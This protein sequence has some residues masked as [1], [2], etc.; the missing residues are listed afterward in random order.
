MN[1]RAAQLNLTRTHYA[2]PHGL[3]NYKNVSSAKDVATLS[4]IAM[5]D[6]TFRRIVNKKTY[7]CEIR[8]V[9]DECRTIVWK[10]TNKL[11]Y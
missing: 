5:E 2:N 4:K 6:E 3:S 11:L 8:S 7:P 9:F 10:N 1:H